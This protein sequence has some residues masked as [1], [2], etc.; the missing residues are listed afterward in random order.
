M[1]DINGEPMDRE[2]CG[3]LMVRAQDFQTWGRVLQ[4]SRQQHRDKPGFTGK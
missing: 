2:K 4:F 3:K 1:D